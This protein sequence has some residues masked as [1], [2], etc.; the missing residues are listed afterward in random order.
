MLTLVCAVLFALHIVLLGRG[1]MRMDSLTFFLVQLMTAAA[2]AM[3]AGLVWGGPVRWSARL[4]VALAVT[5][6]L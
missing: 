6:V 5:G 1:G 4:T 2:L 3:A